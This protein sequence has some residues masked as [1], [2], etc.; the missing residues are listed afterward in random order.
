[1]LPK[2]LLIE[3]EKLREAKP[4]RVLQKFHKSL[5]VAGRC[6]PLFFQ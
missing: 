3:H 4:F 5:T 6:R 1:M 2:T